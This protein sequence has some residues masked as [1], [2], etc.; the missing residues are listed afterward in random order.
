[1]KKFRDFIDFHFRYTEGSIQILPVLELQYEWFNS[2]KHSDSKINWKSLTISLKWICFQSYFS[3][4][5]Y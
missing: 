4:K 2:V 1:M 5:K 3:I